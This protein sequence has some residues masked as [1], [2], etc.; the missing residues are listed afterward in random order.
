MAV[1]WKRVM[2]NIACIYHIF[3]VATHTMRITAGD[4]H[5]N[6]ESNLAVRLLSCFLHLILSGSQHQLHGKFFLFL[7]LI[8]LYKSQKLWVWHALSFIIYYIK[9]YFFDI[10]ST[11]PP[12]STN[13]S[14]IVSIRLYWV[15][16]SF[17]W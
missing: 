8:A 9:N 17:V 10:N 15:F 7:K 4:I 16:G 13:F 1:K 14:N 6:H 11:D 5:K 3:P 12:L 2:R